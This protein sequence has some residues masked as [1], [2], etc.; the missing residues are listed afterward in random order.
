[1]LNWDLIKNP[2]NWVIIFLMVLIAAMGIHQLCKL[3]GNSSNASQNAQS[4]STSPYN[5]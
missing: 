4:N 2:F 1:M 3:M 5:A